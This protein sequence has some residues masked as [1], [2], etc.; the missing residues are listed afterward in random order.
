MDRAAAPAAAAAAPT[1]ASSVEEDKDGDRGGRERKGFGCGKERKGR[2][3]HTNERRRRGRGRDARIGRSGADQAPN[4]ER[5]KKKNS[6]GLETNVSSEQGGSSQVRDREGGFFG[7]ENKIGFFLFFFAPFFLAHGPPPTLTTC[8]LV[9]PGTRHSRVPSQSCPALS[10]HPRNILK[11][12][13]AEAGPTHRQ[14][15]PLNSGERIL[16][17]RNAS[18]YGHVGRGTG[19]P[20]GL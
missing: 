12:C 20:G 5:K 3:G 4:N 2:E 9:S 16:R 14:G 18:L 11:G 19:A 6:R 1:A 7:G 10:R 8:N 17:L 15:R 13:S